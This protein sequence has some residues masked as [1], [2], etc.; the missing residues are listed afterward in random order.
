MEWMQQVSEEV[1]LERIDRNLIPGPQVW[2]ARGLTNL[3]GI[4][5]DNY[6]LRLFD[7]SRKPRMG[8]VDTDGNSYAGDE[9]WRII[10]RVVYP[11]SFVVPTSHI[12]L[13]K[14]ALK[15]IIPRSMLPK[16]LILKLPVSD[17]WSRFYNP[18]RWDSKAQNGLEASYEIMLLWML[19][20][21]RRRKEISLYINMG[22]GWMVAPMPVYHMES[23]FLIP[24]CRS[25]KIMHWWAAPH[26]FSFFLPTGQ[27]LP[28]K[29][30]M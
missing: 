13:R 1:A 5:W 19:R 22:C 29:I 10:Y 23:R 21:L 18:E 8:T 17:R 2:R 6:L 30:G 11:T 24:R 4:K 15:W 26:A 28:G 16:A 7:D 25:E 20:K 3:R 12:F 14:S 9:G 27:N